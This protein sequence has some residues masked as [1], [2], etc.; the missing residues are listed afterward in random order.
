MVDQHYLG[1]GSLGALVDDFLEPRLRAI[2]VFADA[3]G[4][5]TIFRIQ[6]YQRELARLQRRQVDGQVSNAPQVSAQGPYRQLVLIVF[7]R[8]AQRVADSGDSVSER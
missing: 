4:R 2:V 5:K 3:C 6:D 1:P 8:D 7:A